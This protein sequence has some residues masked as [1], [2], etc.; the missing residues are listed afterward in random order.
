MTIYTTGVL[1]Q[2]ISYALCSW[3]MLYTLKVISRS[4][5]LFFQMRTSVFTGGFYYQLFSI[6]YLR[7]S[8]CQ[9]REVC[10]KPQVPDCQFDLE[11]H[12]PLWAL[13]LH[14]RTQTWSVPGGCL[15]LFGSPS[16]AVNEHAEEFPASSVIFL[17]TLS[18]REHL[19][20]SRGHQQQHCVPW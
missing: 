1:Q 14:W 11:Q 12:R 17:P 2:K 4:S 7:S 5:F 10:T 3:I 19:A 16:W 20:N 15:C 13:L 18:P 8:I 6:Y 9:E